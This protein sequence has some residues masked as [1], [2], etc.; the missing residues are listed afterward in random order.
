MG[1]PFKI[2]K[3]ESQEFWKF[4]AGTLVAL[5]FFFALLLVIQFYFRGR[6]WVAEYGHPLFFAGIFVFALAVKRIP[7]NQMG[8]SRQHIGGHLTIGI[9]CGGLIVAA[10]PLLDGLISVSGLSGQELFSEGVKQRESGKAGFPHPLNLFGQVLLFP[11]LK[12]FFFTGLVFQNLRSK[13]NPILA[14]YITALIFAL[15]HFQLNLGLFTLGLIAAF[16]FQ[17]TGTLY[18]SIL[19]HAG[20]SLAGLLVVY[21]YPRLT[22]V[23]VFLF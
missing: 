12:Q 4:N 19:F 3:V 22:T 20:C 15:G 14:V 2:K 5:L 21:V 1:F 6:P 18:A 9:V 11:L 16:L 8:F 10:L 17:L 23:M 7:L 13:F